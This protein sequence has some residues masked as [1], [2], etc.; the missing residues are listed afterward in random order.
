MDFLSTVCIL[1]AVLA[2]A[3]FLPV[4]LPDIT[5]T[6]TITVISIV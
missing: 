2:R 3:D 1:L 6:G 4:A 5:E